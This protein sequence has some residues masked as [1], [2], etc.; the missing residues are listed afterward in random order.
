MDDP[1]PPAQR[2]READTDADD[3]E[4]MLPEEGDREIAGEAAAR[5]MIDASGRAAIDEDADGLL[6]H[7]CGRR[8][9]HLGLCAWKAHDL[10]AAEYREAHGLARSRGLVANSTRETI[11]N[12]ARRTFQFKSRF[13]A[14]RDPAAAM[15]TRLSKGDDMSPAGLAASR[16]RRGHGR[17]GTVVACAWCGASFC[18]LAGARRRRFCSRSCARRATRAR[19]L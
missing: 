2:Q 4:F 11:T 13:V 15:A 3:H 16:A 7:E 17:L 6:C 12:N 1:D 18:P 19:S 8:F 5:R 10:T 9:A 14:A